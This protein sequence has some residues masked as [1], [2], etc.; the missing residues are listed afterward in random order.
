MMCK[1]ALPSRLLAT[2][3][4]PEVTFKTLLVLQSLS[5]FGVY[6]SVFVCMFTVFVAELAMPL[7]P[8]I[9]GLFSFRIVVGG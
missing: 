8:P 3:E 2:P 7:E 5:R 6:S 1:G 9:A 4:S